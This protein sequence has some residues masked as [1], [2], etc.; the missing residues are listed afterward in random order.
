MTAFKKRLEKE[1]N[2]RRNTWFPCKSWAYMDPAT[3]AREMKASDE[4]AALKNTKLTKYL[5]KQAIPVEK[6]RKIVES[7]NCP[8]C[9]Y[10]G[11][12]PSYGKRFITKITLLDGTI[13]PCKIPFSADQ[14]F[15]NLGF[16][17]EMGGFKVAKWVDNIEIEYIWY[18]Y[19]GYHWSQVDGIPHE[20]T[21]TICRN[22]LY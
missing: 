12:S 5:A 22:D 17:H 15:I 9:K 14:G 21:K 3:V 19:R 18:D 6:V 8:N 16:I 1:L 20:A 4:K 11:Q 13:I 7:R 2:R 10:F